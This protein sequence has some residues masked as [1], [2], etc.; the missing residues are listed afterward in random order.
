MLRFHVRASSGPR[1]PVWPEYTPPARSTPFSPRPPL[2]QLIVA[3]DAEVLADVDED[4][5]SPLSLLAGLLTHPYVSVLRFAERG[6]PGHVPRRRHELMGEYVPGWIV[7]GEPAPDHQPVITG[8]EAGI[9]RGGI[10]GNGADVAEADTDNPAY[11][12]LGEAD[13]RAR[14]RADAIAVQAALTARADLF[15]TR[16]AYLHA[17][18][19]DLAGGVLIATPEDSLPL[20]GLYL[21]SQGE[22]VVYRSI[23]GGAT[24]TFNR[25]LFY[26][27]GT[28][29]LLP[30]G[31]RWFSA[32][33]RAS[34]KDDS[35]VYLAQSVFQRV[36]RALL[37]RDG[38]LRALNAEPTNDTAEEAL[39]NL[40][41][42]VL[43]LMG[44]VDATARVAHRAL[45]LPGSE[46]AAA[47]HRPGS[48]RRAL[49][50]ASPE[51]AAA[52]AEGSRLASVLQILSRLR[53]S[54]HGAALDALS[55]QS[56]AS[57]REKTLVGLPHDDAMA[58]VAAMD[59]I[60]GP[61]AW[62]VQE[63]IPDRFHV[64]PGT[65]IE[66][67]VIETVGVL[68]ELMSLTPVEQ[69]PGSHLAEGHGG[70]PDDHV[71]GEANRLSIRWQLG[72]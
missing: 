45:Q 8:T 64:E 60:D 3:V 31:W 29:E 13:A 2:R 22:F 23:D 36:Q 33:V 11:A 67:V 12:E 58:L 44:A 38:A 72:F 48:W 46:R 24:S 69:L 42:I 28:R 16:R 55:V 63:L 51:L 7:L 21:R 18:T 66:R 15:L 19:W 14:R 56:D 68:N 5:L 50:N 20:V 62:S 70:P 34:S 17:L 65:L 37:A 40:D 25:G 30:A 61:G 57:R 35:L 43:E 6:P 1:R 9:H 59:A 53:N 39:A 27:V 47:W 71:F 41:I 32:C 10:M 54:I 4:A 52:T 49:V 26:W